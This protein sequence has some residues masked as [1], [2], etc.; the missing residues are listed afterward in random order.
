MIT[1]AYLVNRCPSSALE[2]KTQEEKWSSR[3]P[4]LNHLRVFGCSAYVHQS[5]GKLEPRAIKCVF[6]GY[7]QGT[8]G[9]RLWV[10]KGNGFKIINSRD[11]IFNETL[12]PCQS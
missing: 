5:Q 6:F 2:F 12:F 3:P 8:K 10:R 4:N 7:S 11:V 1:T 9:Y